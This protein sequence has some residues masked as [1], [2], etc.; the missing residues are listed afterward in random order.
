MRKAAK[1][2]ALCALGLILVCVVLRVAVF[3]QFS[4]RIPLSGNMGEGLPVSVE[5]PDILQAGTP[6]KHGGYLRIP[7]S[8]KRP[9]KTDLRLGSEEDGT[10]AFLFLQVD[11]SL[12]VY[13]LTNGN[14]TGDTGVLI[15]VTLFWLLVSA[16]M[17]WHFF[18]AKGARFYDYGTIYYSGFSLFALSSGLVMLSVTVSHLAHPD[19]YSMFSAYSSISGASIHY[20]MMTMPLVLLF[21]AA[22]AVSNIVLLRHQRPRVQNALGLL[23]STLLI[24]GEVVGWFLFSRDFMG[25]EWEY[26]ISNTVENTYATVF[27]YFQCMLTGAVICGVRAA[28]HIPAPDKD[29]IIIHGCW[30][31][32]DGTLPPLLRA[33]ADKA[34]EFWRAQKK[35]TGKE[36]R[37]IPSGGRGEDEPMPEA[38][39]IRRYLMAEGVEDRLI[40]P[41][42]QSANTYENMAFSGKIIQDTD[43]DGRVVFATSSYHVFRSGLWARQAGL[44][45]EGIG[46]RTKWWFWPNAFMRE[47]AGLLLKRWK[48]ELLFLLLLVLFFSLLSMILY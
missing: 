6:E 19:N 23:V 10:A 26:R 39:A 7:I 44:S 48:Q 16:I 40:L 47:T 28:R 43:P 45:A 31:R 38:E 37:F 18:Q 27:V 14:F 22:M 46:G 9:G 25:S 36:A 35:K 2:I 30:F 17:L 13:D 1:Q 34:L 11:R 5:R 20:M 29:F 4:V 21:A 42:V 15:T 12:T 3:N 8:P 32:A 41:E 33:R 24:A